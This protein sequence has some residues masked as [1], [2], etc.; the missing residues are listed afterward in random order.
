MGSAGS[1]GG[2]IAGA[3]G[4]SGGAAGSAGAGG[5]SGDAGS[6]GI[7]GQ[8]GGAAGSAGNAAGSSGSAGGGTISGTPTEDALADLEAIRQEH[9]VVA[10]AGEVYLIGGYVANTVSDSVIAYDPEEDS[11]R[12]VEAFPAPL[13]HGNAGVVGDKLYVAGFYINGGMSSATAQV[14]EYDP[15]A[16]DWTEK[17]SMPAGTERAASCVAV[18]GG[19]MYVIGGAVG[20]MSV[21][22]VSRY[23]VAADEWEV[24]PN[25]PERREHCVAGAV[26]GIIYVAGGR[27]DGIT[28]IQPKTWA[29]DPAAEMW[30]EKAPLPV[31]R[32]GL[33]GAVLG[34]KLFVFGGEGNADAT[35]GVFPDIDA[36]D[37][38]ENS[39]EA[40]EPMAVPRHGFGAA[41]LGDAIYLMG[42]ATRQGGGAADDNSVFYFAPAAGGL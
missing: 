13:N 10:L 21:N 42:G 15:S 23:D 14:F 40:L 3:A 33:A 39:W 4:A 32:G 24:L 16:D 7:G 20:G 31:P 34:N 41:T 19:F 9:A 12:D 2:G 36:Y 29:Y 26:G 5:S 17:A 30:T 6:G 22:D 25:L 18:D 27:A 8:A 38:V 37:P 35:S 1:A 28:G 11:F